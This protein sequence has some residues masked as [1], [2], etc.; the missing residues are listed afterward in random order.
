MRALDPRLLRHA[1]AVR[2]LI[3]SSALVG[4]LNA[5]ATVVLAAALADLVTAYAIDRAEPSP[6]SLPALLIAVGVKAGA[7]W[8]AEA[9]PRRSSVRMVNQL[10]TALLDRV[11]GQD[12]TWTT[13]QRPA[14]L[15]QLATAGVGG[16]QNYA[17]RSSR[18][19][20]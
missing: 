4:V 8:A 11:V 2:A 3:L 17:A 15:I 6:L 12:R 18:N 5:V 9:L 16:L 13:R 19:W 7:S 1:S 20:C 10:R 14:E